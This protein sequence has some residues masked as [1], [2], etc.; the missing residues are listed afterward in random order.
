MT[1]LTWLG[2]TAIVVAIAAVLGIQPKRTRPVEHTHM[3]GMARGALLVLGIILAG[4][5][6]R[7]YAI[8]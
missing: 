1:W 5:A 3:M 6:L 7:A 2:L 4:L 8:G